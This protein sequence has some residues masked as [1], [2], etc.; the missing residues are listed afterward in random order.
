[1]RPVTAR[2]AI[3]EAV[4]RIEAQ[5]R[6]QQVSRRRAAAPG[7]LGARRD[8]PSDA[9]HLPARQRDQRLVQLVED[10]AAIRAEGIDNRHKDIVSALHVTGYRVDIL[11]SKLAAMAIDLRDRLPAQPLTEDLPSP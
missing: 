10:H 1:M 4:G 9:G 6:E 11:Q 8:G 3:A 2:A 7:A 5:L